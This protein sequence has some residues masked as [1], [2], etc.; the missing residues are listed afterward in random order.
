MAKYFSTPSKNFHTQYGEEENCHLKGGKSSMERLLTEQK[1]NLTISTVTRSYFIHSMDRCL[2]SHSSVPGIVP[3]NNEQKHGSYPPRA[4]SL[5]EEI[6]IHSPSKHVIINCH[7]NY[8][9]KIREPGVPPEAVL[10]ASITDFPKRRPADRTFH[11]A[12]VLSSYTLQP[13][14]QLGQAHLC[15]SHLPV[16]SG[17]TCLPANIHAAS[18]QESP[19]F[20]L[21]FPFSKLFSKRQNICSPTSSSPGDMLHIYLNFCKSVINSVGPFQTLFSSYLQSGLTL[22]VL[23][24][25]KGHCSGQQALRLCLLALHKHCHTV[26]GSRMSRPQPRSHTLVAAQ[27]PSG[28]LSD[29]RN[30]PSMATQDSQCTSGPSSHAQSLE[31]PG[32]DTSFSPGKEKKISDSKDFSDH[33]DSGC[34]QKPWTEQS[35]GPERGDQVPMAPSQSLLPGRGGSEPQRQRHLENS[36]EPQERRS[37]V[38]SVIREKLQEILQDLGL[39]PEASLPTTPSC[40]QQTWKTSAAFSPQKMPL[41]KELGFSP[42]MVRRRRATQQARSHF[43][44]SAPSSVGHRTNRT[45]SGAHSRLHV[46]NGDSPSLA[47][48]TADCR[49][50]RPSSRKPSLPSDPQDRRGTLEGSRQSQTEPEGARGSKAAFLPQPSGSGL[51]SSPAAPCLSKASP[52]LPEQWH[53][54]P[55]VPSGCPSLS[56]RHSCFDTESSSSDEFFCHCHR[57]YCEICFQSSS[58][59]SDSGT[60]DTDPEP[61]EGAG[62]LGKAVGPLQA[63]CELQR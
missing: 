8:E 35:L 7:K 44:G 21:F 10:G 40:H 60:S 11:K 37:R 3:M 45:F 20:S 29:F 39:G 18:R 30:D 56:S 57:P 17:R 49:T 14:S 5:V 6:E 32:K 13:I 43:P 1:Q 24:K 34:S 4:H 61:T 54:W 27:G 26:W 51:A 33:L 16:L 47:P 46:Q 38:S 63:Y 58:D 22:S 2:M 9:R 28:H 59:S 50:G 31:G 19:P 12:E 52:D 42:Y 41:S 25:V 48:Q 15:S 36:E 53:L 23:G 62:F 55:P